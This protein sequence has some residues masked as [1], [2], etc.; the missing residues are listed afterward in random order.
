MI[1]RLP[2]QKYLQEC[3]RYEPK[4]GRLFWK[5]RPRQHFTS[6]R[7]CKS[8]NTRCA[9][10]EAFTAI[11]REYRRKHIMFY[12]HGSIA[13]ELYKAHRVIW[14]LVTGKEPP[15]IIDHEDRNGINNRRNNLRAASHGQNFVNRTSAW[16][17]AKIIG[18]RRKP[19]KF[20]QW[21]ARIHVDKKCIDLGWFEKKS[22]AVAARR[23]AEKKFY[24]AFAP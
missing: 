23:T 10:K 5:K 7:T 14:K 11:V 16:G 20:R 17:T 21:N 9:G 4:T 19:H 2:A 12:K 8:V 24:G 15:A 1:K 13:G 6:D 18:I 22:E 3:F